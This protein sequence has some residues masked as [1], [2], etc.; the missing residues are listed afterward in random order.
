MKNLN[1]EKIGVYG[2]CF[3]IAAVSLYIDFKDREAKRNLMWE[4]NEIMNDNLRAVQ[5]LESRKWWQF[6]VLS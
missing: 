1:W 6:R 4:A 5:R 3:I 2:V